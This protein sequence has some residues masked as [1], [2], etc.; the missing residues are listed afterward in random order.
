MLKYFQFG[1]QAVLAALAFALCFWFPGYAPAA[2]QCERV[3][4][5]RPVAEGLV[6]QKVEV[7]AG[8]GKVLVYVLRVDLANPYLKVNT[9][10]GAAGTLDKN[11]SVTDMA[12]SAGAVAAVNADFF[13]MEESGRPIGMTFKDGRLVTS[14]PL[15]NDMFGWAVTSSGVPLI[16]IFNFSGKVTARNGA[17]FPLSGLN[18]PSYIESGGKNSH[19]DALLLYDRFWGRSS[20]GRTDDKDSV[21]EVFVNNGVV[22]EIL[23]NQP[24]KSIPENGFVLAGRGRAAEFIKSNIRVG[25]KITV[26]YRVEPEGDKI[27]AGTGG[28]SL[29]VDHGRALG[30]FSGTINEP[31]ARTALAYSH[32]RK[33]MLLVVVEKGPA[34]R[35]FTLDELAE[36][37]V[38]LKADR[39][40]NLDGGGST[41]LAARPLGEEKAVLVNRPLKDT[42][43]AVPTAV[44]FFSSAPRGSL[45]GLVLKGPKAVFPGDV[46]SFT[47]KGYDSHYNPLPVTPERVRWTLVSGPGTLAGNVFTAGGG[48]EAVIEAE[49]GGLRAAVSIKV[50]GP[51]DLKKITVEPRS[52]SVSPGGKVNLTVNA[53]GRDDTVYTLSP[54][55]YTAA[56]D[57]L[58]GRLEDG[59]FMAA[60]TPAA[61]EIK[62]SCGELSVA[63]PVVVKRDDQAVAKISPGRPG[64][65]ALGELTVGFPGG[66]FGRP[67]TVLAS[68]GGELFSPVPS[69][70]KSV[71]TVTLEVL[72]ADPGALAEPAA[73]TWKFQPAQG[74]RVAVLQLLKGRWQEIPSRLAEE[75]NLVSC[76]IWE[77]AP[78]ALVR[79]EQPPPVFADLAGHWAA[80]PVSRL[81]AA[82]IVSGYPGNKFDPSRKIT[83]AELVVMICRALGWQPAGGEGEFRDNA[84]IPAW[85]RGYVLAAAG[86]G[87]VSGYGDGTF[88]PSKEVSR[89]EMAAMIHRA[90]SLPA[91]EGVRPAGV[92]TDGA[93]VPAWA[94]DPV[95][96]V[97][98]A[99]IMKGDN[100]GKFRP[101]DGASRAESAATIVRVLD[102]LLSR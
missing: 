63:I 39:A 84:E 48:G 4:E 60:G 19:E 41:T 30:G 90:L 75:E 95:A 99:G 87:V 26:E 40:L 80:G 59:V 101:A 97:Y 58:L 65:L 92:F 42:Q 50:L 64:S 16:D 44:G 54:R 5:I 68:Y 67:V 100:D 82:G 34:S 10:V 7:T 51:R 61:G 18:K 86:R 62:I 37:L 85:S 35:G 81:A 49:S 1:K 78:L 3:L 94:R 8:G 28:W 53:V 14:P 73:V 2:I 93:A 6:L 45:A 22:A 98:A 76:R 79:D 74:G 88:R 32:D 102:Y 83:R 91:G 36:Y 21:T 15:R 23:V 55:N 33:T 89:S 52:I 77:L 27:W 47:L 96:A 25:E 56:A 72:G 71:S 66:A 57:P 29:L 12:V 17:Q 24:G 38:S 11:A 9:L 69:R 20:R 46:V 13:Q 31:N 70:Y 43:R